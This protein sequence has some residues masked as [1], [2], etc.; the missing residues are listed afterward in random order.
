MTAV[1]LNLKH[2]LLTVFEVVV[3][4]DEGACQVLVGA[5][6]VLVGWG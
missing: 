5:C 3:V 2:T 1:G 6:Q 4:V